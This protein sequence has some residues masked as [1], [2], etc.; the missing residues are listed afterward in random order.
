[1]NIILLWLSLFLKI[2]IAL[3]L[4]VLLFGL[5]IALESTVRRPFE[6]ST[7]TCNSMLR[8]V[9][10]CTRRH[11]LLRLR[12]STH[13]HC[14]SWASVYTSSSEIWQAS[15]EWRMDW[16]TAEVRHEAW[17]HTLVCR[18]TLKWS[19]IHG[20]LWVWLRGYSS[21]HWVHHR[22]EKSKDLLS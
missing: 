19:F 16:G 5:L 17:M 22:L 10:S 4:M 7:L 15:I 18:I 21:R 1:M 20:V 6:T 8:Q 14:V 11:H 2:G 13:E 12:M 9:D 3:F